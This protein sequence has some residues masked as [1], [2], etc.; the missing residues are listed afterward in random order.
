MLPDHVLKGS[1]DH[2]A[3]FVIPAVRGLRLELIAQYQQWLCSGGTRMPGKEKLRTTLE[4]RL[5]ALE[6]FEAVVNSG[7]AK[8]SEG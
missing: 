4:A 5:A 2:E 6:A 7:L 3:N 8:R 1:A